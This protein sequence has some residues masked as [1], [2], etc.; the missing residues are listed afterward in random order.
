MKKRIGNDE[1]IL[2]VIIGH[3]PEKIKDIFITI[4]IDLG[5]PINFWI[6]ST[7]KY[8]CPE[9]DDLSTFHHQLIDFGT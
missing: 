2:G 1:N 6:Q 9:L 7:Q 8:Y 4:T 5:E 3:K